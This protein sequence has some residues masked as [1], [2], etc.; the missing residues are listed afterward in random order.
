MVQ[1]EHDRNFL[2]STKG[3]LYLG[4]YQPPL[5]QSFSIIFLIPGWYA[6]IIL[7][8]V[9]LWYVGKRQ[10]AALLSFWLGRTWPRLGVLVFR[11]PTRQ[12]VPRCNRIRGE[13]HLTFLLPF[14]ILFH[15]VFRT[16]NALGR[17][18]RN[19]VNG[20]RGRHSSYRPTASV[21]V[22]VSPQ[23]LAAWSGET[24]DR[25]KIGWLQLATRIGR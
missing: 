1:P 4:A 24:K 9:Y 8:T 21:S 5:P 7:S 12:W 19:G 13:Y 10:A 14:V 17:N 23:L 18:I 20:F 25:W 6:C 3:V 22:P 16:W 11:T 15:R 2:F